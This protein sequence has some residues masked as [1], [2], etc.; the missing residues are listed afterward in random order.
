MLP[1]VTR[2]LLPWSAAGRPPGSYGWPWAFCWFSLPW[3]SWLLGRPGASGARRTLRRITSRVVWNGFPPCGRRRFRATRQRLSDSVSLGYMLSAM[4]GV[5]LI[6][7]LSLLVSWFARVRKAAA[8]EPV[9]VSGRRRRKNFVEKTLHSL[10]R[11]R[12]HALFA[13]ETAQAPGLLQRLDARVK[14]VGILVLIFAAVALHRLSVLAALL[15]ACVL[16]VDRVPH[17]S[18]AP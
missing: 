6:V 7:L 2:P 5:G 12:Q 15:A 4:A 9:P 11:V 14:L 3:A 8:S 18:C 13:E 1:I 10:F 16:L 17:S